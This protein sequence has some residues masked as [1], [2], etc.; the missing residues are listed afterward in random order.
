MLLVSEETISKHVVEHLERIPRRVVSLAVEFVE[1]EGLWRS[2]KAAG[3]RVV[4][5]TTSRGG[6]EI[7]GSAAVSA[8]EAQAIVVL[9]A[10]LGVG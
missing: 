5:V 6:V 4:R 10:A 7:V 3:E 1:V 8:A 2:T 9:T